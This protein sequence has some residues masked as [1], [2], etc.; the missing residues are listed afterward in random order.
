[1][2]DQIRSAVAGRVLVGHH[3]RV[4]LGVLTWELSDLPAARLPMPATRA[5]S[6]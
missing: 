6:E 3:V 2:A 1:V 5:C 4:D